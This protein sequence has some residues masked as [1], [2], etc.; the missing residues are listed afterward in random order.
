MYRIWYLRCDFWD[1]EFDFE[2]L[3]ALDVYEGN[4][5]V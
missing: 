5:L 2:A 3:Y 4:K 1:T